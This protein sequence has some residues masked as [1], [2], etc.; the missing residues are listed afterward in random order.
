MEVERGREGKGRNLKESERERR[1]E[2][3]WLNGKFPSVCLGKFYPPKFFKL[4][5]KKRGN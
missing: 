4:A 1:E 5:T 2:N 3:R